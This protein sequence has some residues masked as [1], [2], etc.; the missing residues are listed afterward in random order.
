VTDISGVR[1]MPKAILLVLFGVL[2]ASPAVALVAEDKPCP[3]GV[4]LGDGCPNPSSG[5]YR[6]PNFFSGYAN[7]SFG[8]SLPGIRVLQHAAYSIRPPWNVAGVDYAVGLPASRFPVSSL[9]DPANIAKDPMANPDGAGQDCTFTVASVLAPNGGAA[10]VCTKVAPGAVGPV[11][12]GYDFGGYGFAS[13]PVHDCVALVI[14]DNSWASI[15]IT[16]DLFVNGPNCNNWSHGGS[17]A[18][19]AFQ[20][21]FVNGP[22]VFPV[23]FSHNTIYG[24]A[25]DNPGLVEARLCGMTFASS[26]GVAIGDN[27][28]W[29]DYP[30]GPRTVEYNAFIHIPGR[31]IQGDRNCGGYTDLTR[32]N[33]TEGFVY[34]HGRSG[35]HGEFKEYGVGCPGSTIVQF[36]YNVSLQT[37]YVDAGVGEGSAASFYYSAGSKAAAIK[38]SGSI[39]HNVFVTNLNP[40]YPPYW[41]TSVAAVS[42]SYNNFGDTLVSKNYVDPT[43]SA[44]CFAQVSRPTFSG[45]TI[46]SGNK[47]LLSSAGDGSLNGFGTTP[48][49][50]YG[51]Q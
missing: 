31:V 15:A 14:K 3:R 4:G 10:V 23:T 26:G 7:Q 8:R 6:Q 32:Y 46:F 48:G 1:T 47:N 16:D 24:C 5:S 22:R 13:R 30:D 20:V 34:V 2:S 17:S 44:S 9:K 45:R 29:A 35:E 39:S 38:F 28:F 36:N 40:R 12:D 27:H 21:E 51:T 49:G 19:N 25:P 18:A 42:F 41:T 37:R 11:I 50:C 43:G 33:Y